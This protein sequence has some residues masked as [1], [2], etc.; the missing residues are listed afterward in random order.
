MKNEKKKMQQPSFP[1]RLA[2]LRKKKGFTQQ[3][4]AEAIGIHVTQLSRYESGV[5]QP[6]LDVIRNIAIALSVTADEL[7]FDDDERGPADELRLQFEAV[8]RFNAE[9]KKV[10]KSVLESLILKHEANRWSSTT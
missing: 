9:E 10:L 2:A 1:A 5:S 4:L 7:I 3:T 6:T 8:S